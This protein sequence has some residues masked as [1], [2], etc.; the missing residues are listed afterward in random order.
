MFASSRALDRLGNHGKVVT[1][2]TTRGFCRIDCVI[3]NKKGAIIRGLSGIRK[4]SPRHAALF[5]MPVSEQ[6]NFWMKGMLFHIDVV[7]FTRQGVASSVFENCSPG[8]LESISSKGPARFALESAAG[9]S[10]RLGLRVG[11][12]LAYWQ[13]PLRAKSPHFIKYSRGASRIPT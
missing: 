7:M 2:R 10:G 11:A 13:L 4:L 3:I 6:Q 12:R 8:S 5:V 9:V 1:V